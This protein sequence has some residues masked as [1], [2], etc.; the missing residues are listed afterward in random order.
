VFTYDKHHEHWYVK[1]EKDCMVEWIVPIGLG[2]HTAHSR[3]HH[4][5]VGLC[6]TVDL[7]QMISFN[8]ERNS[9]FCYK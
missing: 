6:D 4:V 7:I 3:D 8:V 2:R 1:R 9:R 5:P